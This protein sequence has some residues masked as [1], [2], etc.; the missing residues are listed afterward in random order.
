MAAGLRKVVDERLYLSKSRGG[1]VLRREV[2]V[3]AGG[4]VVRYHL[5]YVNHLVY[6][7]D[8]GRVLGYDSAHGSHHRHFKG[9]VTAVAFD[10][11]E[12][13]QARFEKEWR[14]LVREVKD[15]QD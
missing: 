15:A 6:A 14:G 10:N 4:L 2:W 12:Q 11:F 3:D 5:A 7:G 13:L 9:K 8:N 1:G